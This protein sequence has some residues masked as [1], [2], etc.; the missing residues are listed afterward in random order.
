M[1]RRRR[2]EEQQQE[3][4]EEEEEEE[5]EEAG[6][7]D[8]EEARKVAKRMALAALRSALDELGEDKE[9]TKAVLVERLVAAQAAAA[10]GEAEGSGKDG[11]EE[12]EEEA[13]K[14]APS[15]ALALR[16]EFRAVKEAVMTGTAGQHEIRRV[17]NPGNCGVCP[18]FDRYTA[19]CRLAC[20]TCRVRLCRHTDCWHL[21]THQGKGKRVPATMNS[22]AVELAV[23]EDQGEKKEVASR[24]RLTE[25]PPPQRRRGA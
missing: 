13:Y 15:W 10:A 3:E 1:P 14:E 8:E 7:F 18:E 11:E 25:P 12:E 17:T 21:H 24:A 16:D 9:G 23:S 19:G 22:K 6:G 2:V 5:E 4:K 20:I